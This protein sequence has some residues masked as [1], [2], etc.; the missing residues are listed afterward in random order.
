MV[1]EMHNFRGG[2][3]A[4]VRRHLL[5]GATTAVVLAGTFSLGRIS[6]PA[7]DEQ[8]SR[9]IHRLANEVSRLRQEQL[10]PATVLK[11]HRD[12]ICYL[13]GS[14]SFGEGYAGW[15]RWPSSKTKFSGT[16]FV[17][18]RGLIATNRHVAEPWFDDPESETIVERGGK[19][20]LESLLAYCPNMAKPFKLGGVVAS[21]SADVAVA[22]YDPGSVEHEL[23]PLPLAPGAGVPGDAV[24]VVGYPMGVT[25][26]V[27]KSP[28]PIYEK[29]ADRENDMEV[30]TELAARAL[31][32]PSVTHGHLGDVLGEKLIYDAATAHGGSG[33]PVFNSQGK[34]IGVNSAYLDGFSGSSLGVSIEALRPLIERAGAK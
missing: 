10:M 30:V 11:Q 22:R 28:K 31:I 25:A 20:R 18:A 7:L 2:R 19:P 21:S 23:H 5:W 9:E 14:Y 15:G 32:R 33:G 4:Q 1:A 3:G 34:V 24:V 26:M 16:G 17:V 6:Q 8:T 29:L 12:S 13:Q 27:A